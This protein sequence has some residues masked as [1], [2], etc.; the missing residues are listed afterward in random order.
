MPAPAVAPLL[1]AGARIAPFAGKVALALPA[2][3]AAKGVTNM[4]MENNTRDAMDPAMEKLKQQQQERA[5][6]EAMERQRMAETQNRQR[7]VSDNSGST[8][9]GFG[10]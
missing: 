10:N 6:R 2:H 8:T 4:L 1:A 3:L 9:T 7:M 5:Q